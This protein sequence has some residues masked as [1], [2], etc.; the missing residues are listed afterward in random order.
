MQI[1]TKRLEKD[2]KPYK[3]RIKKR[4]NNE[5]KDRIGKDR[6]NKAVQEQS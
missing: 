1:E 5:R 4:W 2:G 3:K 6:P